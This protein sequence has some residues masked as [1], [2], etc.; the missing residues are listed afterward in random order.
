[1]MRLLLGSGGL[2]TKEKQD[3]WVNC[4][5][6]FLKDIESFLFI[7]FAIKDHDHYVKRL[8]ELGFHADRE[9]KGLHS[10]E[11]PE[12]AIKKAKAIYTGGGN[13]FL[14]AK[15]L[16]D[17]G[18]VELVK[19]KVRAGTPYIGISA[20]SNIACP[21][22]ATTNDMPIVQPRSFKGF[23]LI[24]FQINPHFIPSQVYI[25]D[26]NGELKPYGGESRSVR[27]QEFHQWNEKPV[28]ALYE[29]AVLEVEDKQAKIFGRPAARLFR[30][31]RDPV[32]LE[33]GF[34]FELN[35]LQD[36]NAQS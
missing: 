26:E 27:I 9:V 23:N 15:E 7:P 20:G 17:R 19:E 14:L 2:S 30:K 1:M 25:K 28:L 18:L 21:S 33:A 3:L 6:R 13:S 34:E 35:S 24:P 4:L 32:D 10:A 8:T 5:D 31:S 12:Q 16:W 22:I 29:G 11:D 36:V